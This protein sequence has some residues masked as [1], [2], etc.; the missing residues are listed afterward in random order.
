MSDNDLFLNNNNDDDDDFKVE[1]FEDFTVD[2][3]H[4]LFD[5]HLI[6]DIHNNT[7][8]YSYAKKLL[9]TRATS[10]RAYSNCSLAYYNSQRSAGLGYCC[11]CY[12]NMA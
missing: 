7:Y 12:G 6:K 9:S 11:G 2:K 8:K 5:N 4:N 1:S 10:I 3:W